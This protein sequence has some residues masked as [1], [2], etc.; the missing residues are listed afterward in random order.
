MGRFLSR[1]ERAF[2]RVVHTHIVVH[3]VLCTACTKWRGASALRFFSRL[4]YLARRTVLPELSWIPLFPP[5]F[6][7]CTQLSIEAMLSLWKVWKV[8]NCHNLKWNH[9]WDGYEILGPKEWLFLEVTWLFERW[10]FQ[11]SSHFSCCVNW[12]QTELQTC[13]ETEAQS[14]RKVQSTS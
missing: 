14:N 8:E 1:S 2:C 3:T 12:R 11:C 7:S 9:G 5:F 10:C 13:S 4:F 6:V